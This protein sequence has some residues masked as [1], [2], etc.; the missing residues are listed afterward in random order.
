[1]F[2]LRSKYNKLKA[3]LDESV[4]LA[5]GYYNQMCNLKEEK[6]NLNEEI[7]GAKGLM[8]FGL[9]YSE[10][11]GLLALNS[12]LRQREAILNHRISELEAIIRDLKTGRKSQFSKDEIKAL[13]S[14]CHPDKHNG[15]ESAKNMTAK[16][17]DIKANQ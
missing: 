10:G 8:S 15:K 4:N 2:V 11:Q 9:K 13:V 14:L 1:M 16:L 12:G 3:A 7:H 5:K 6:R 17:L